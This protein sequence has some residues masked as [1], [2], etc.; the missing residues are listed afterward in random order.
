MDLDFKNSWGSK[1]CFHSVGDS[2][3]TEGLSE[4]TKAILSH[5]HLD[6]VCCKSVIIANQLDVYEALEFLSDSEPAY[7]ED[8]H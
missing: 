8:Q 4:D 1:L 7:D 6:L 2:T 3:G 5:L